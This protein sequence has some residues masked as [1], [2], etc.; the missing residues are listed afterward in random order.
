MITKT[1]K[2]ASVTDFIN[3]SSDFDQINF[4]LIINE[5]TAVTKKQSD[6]SINDTCFYC[7]FC[8]FGN[9]KSAYQKKLEEIKLEY[10]SSKF[11]R[12]EMVKL[13]FARIFVN[14]PKN[15]NL[16]TFTSYYETNRIQPWATA[17]LQNCSN[18]PT[19]TALEIPIQNDNTDRDGRIDI[20]AKFNTTHLFLEAKT[21]LQD[22]MNDERFVE[23][24]EKYIHT[25]GQ[26]LSRDNFVL[27]LLI[28]GEEQSLHPPNNVHNLVD[29]GNLTK[30][31]YQLVQT[32]NNRIPFISAAALWAL[33]IRY[34][35]D[36]TFNMIN[37]IH[38][39]FSDLSVFGLL[40]S[41]K[42]IKN[43]SQFKVQNI[44]NW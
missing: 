34:I 20:G 12:G 42:V 5:C 27:L 18:H 19:I 35:E 14:T 13:P 7:N 44:E 43:G 32:G 6:I 41:G 26:C 9:L 28:G 40:T 39:T 29:V 31:F 38:K 11:F 21:T 15:K 22:A 36:P 25:I 3:A 8:Y 30:R 16:A 23:Q 24:Y 1:R 2:Y 17:I 10:P 4:S 37:L 33:S